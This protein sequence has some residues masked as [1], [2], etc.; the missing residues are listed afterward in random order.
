ML[1]RWLVLL[2]LLSPISAQEETIRYCRF[3]NLA[4]SADGQNLFFESYYIED[5]TNQIAPPAILMKNIQT[6]KMVHLNPNIERFAISADKKYLVFSSRFGIFLMDIEK[7]ENCR[8]I[9]VLNPT[10]DKYLHSMGFFESKKGIALYWKM[11]DSFGEEIDLQ[12]MQINS[13]PVQTDSTIYWMNSQQLPK[14]EYPDATLPLTEPGSARMLNH[15]CL[16]MKTRFIFKPLGPKTPDLTDL[17]QRDWS[18]NQEKKLVEKIRPRLFSF[19]PD[20]SRI[21]FSYWQERNGE[22]SQLYDLRKK[23][24]QKISNEVFKF[25]SWLNNQELVGLTPSGLYKINLEPVKLQKLNRWKIPAAY[26][27]NTKNIGTITLANLKSWN[28]KIENKSWSAKIEDLKGDFVPNQIVLTNK[29]TGK[30]K[31]L[32]P[33]MSNLKAKK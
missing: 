13:L 29:Q 19:S 4:W 7:P 17:I 27:T 10:E 15:P 5:G 3:N 25:L 18:S 12:L 9:H 21:V 22:I 1:N 16:K 6:E 24:M 20:S 33:P 31:V 28:K 8:Q 2:A 23:Q 14:K 26:Q 32:V 30:S 11:V